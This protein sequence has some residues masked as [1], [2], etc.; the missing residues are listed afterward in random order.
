MLIALPELADGTATPETIAGSF[1][2]MQMKR[3]AKCPVCRLRLEAEWEYSGT[4][5]GE[6]SQKIFWVNTFDPNPTEEKM[7]P[8]T[9]ADHSLIQLYYTPANRDAAGLTSTTTGTLLTRLLHAI[10]WSEAIKSTVTEAHEKLTKEFNAE[11]AISVINKTLQRRWSC[12]YDEAIDAKPHFSPMSR[13]FEEIV[14]NPAIIF[15]PTPNGHERKL[16]ELSAGQQSLFYF[17]I[18]AAMFDLERQVVA[19]EATGFLRKHL[20]IP[21]LSIFALEEPE[22]H[23]SP[24]YLARIVDQVRTLTKT[25]NAQSIVN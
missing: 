24:H 10:E 12:L 21:A 15:E 9:V 23:L 16:S 19:E 20:H 25:N 6:V 11:T 17:A 1:K 3:D 4:A 18:A 8:I 5:E 13:R 2:N 22:N 14:R 7:H